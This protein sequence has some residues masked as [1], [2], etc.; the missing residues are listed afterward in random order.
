[1]ARIK[2][3]RKATGFIDNSGPSRSEKLADPDSYESRRRKAQAEK[4]KNASVYEK[5][6]QNSDNSDDNQPAERKT[7]LAD[8]IKK[9]NEEKQRDSE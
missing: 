8:K 5:Q 4:K 3:S 1:M 7:R 2:K 6:R 9:L